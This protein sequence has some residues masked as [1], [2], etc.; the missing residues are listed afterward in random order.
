MEVFSKII[1]AVRRNEIQNDL[2]AGRGRH[3]AADK[4][5]NEGYGEPDKHAHGDDDKETSNRLRKVKLSGNYRGQ[6][7]TEYDQRRCIVEQTLTFRY[8]Y[9]D[10]RR[11]HLTKIR[12]PE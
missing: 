10:F 12:G 3:P 2:D 1:H 7:E 11:P 6:G 9:Q 4:I 5:E 8:A